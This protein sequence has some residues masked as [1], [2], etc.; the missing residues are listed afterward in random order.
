MSKYADLSK[1]ELLRL[2]EIQEQELKSKKYGLVWDNEKEPEQVVLDCENNLPILERIS[3][4]QIRTND[5]EDN[6][7]IEWDNYHALTVL[8]YT[9]KEKIDVIYIDPP[10]NTGNKD[11]VYNDRYVD[12][13]D[14]YRHSKWLNFMEKRLNLAKRL[15]KENWL[16]FISIDDNEVAQLKLL[17]DKIFDWNTSK[18]WK[19][20]FIACLPTIMNLKGNNDQFGFAGTHEYTLVYAKNIEKAKVNEFDIDEEEVL[21]KWEEDEI[22]PYK[23]GAN[24]KSTGVN[25][26]RA[27]R[28]NLFFP[29]F[30]NE[31]NKEAYVTENDKPLNSNDIKILPITNKQE[32]SWRWSKTKIRNEQHNIILIWEDWEYSIYKKQ[33]PN[34]GELPSKKPKTLFYKPE[35]SSWNGTALLKDIFQEK[36][37]DNPKPLDLIKDILILST[38]KDS[39]ILDFMAWS[40][41][42]GHA[43]LE[44]NKL[45]NGNR[46]FILCTNNELNGVGSKLA[47]ENPKRNLKELWICQRVTH[48]RLEKVINWYDSIEG[49]GGNLQYF[50]TNFIKKTSSRDQVKF[51]L[52]NK[53]TEMLCVKDNIF[54]LIKEEKNYKIFSSNDKKRFLCIYY[55][56]MKDETDVFMKELKNIKEEKN[57]YMFSETKEVD[58]E[59]FKDIKNYNIEAIPEPILEI[60]R[61][62]VKINISK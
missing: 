21:D 55:N 35:Y 17:C 57:I 44:L 29:I 43:T 11:F 59:I 33:R 8:N 2:I 60:Y 16:I 19:T 46:K 3:E 51:D 24:L 30:I 14:W 9:H 56:F 22:G 32:M 1:E 61:E 5:T 48:P 62:L 31:K 37:F 18:W 7:L 41:T 26:P 12:K 54:N 25:A 45:D 39:I 40:W 10:Y 13:E 42:T 47:E 28:P 4:K 15:L 36:V 52:T 27:K 50:Q 58:L 23:K 38:N 49:T 6:I 20:N 53:C 34:I